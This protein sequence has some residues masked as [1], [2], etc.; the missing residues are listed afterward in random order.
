MMKDLKNIIESLLFIADGPLTVERIKNVLHLSD[1]TEI[2]NM[3][4]ALSEE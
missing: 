2:R 1:A 3:L 4:K